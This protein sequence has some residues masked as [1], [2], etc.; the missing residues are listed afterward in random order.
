[1]PGYEKGRRSGVRQIDPENRAAIRRAIDADLPTLKIDHLL[2]NPQADAG[3]GLASG[4]PR[5]QF[6]KFLEQPVAFTRRDTGTLIGG[7]D[8]DTVC[9]H[10]RPEAVHGITRAVLDRICD[11]VVE[12]LF[13]TRMVGQDDAEEIAGLH[14]DILVKS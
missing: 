2:H 4:A 11:E 7:I 14:V 5:A 13:Q 12:R 3:T 1:M 6:A 8:A 9:M 10:V